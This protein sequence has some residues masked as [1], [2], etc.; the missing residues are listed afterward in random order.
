MV[1]IYS[2][3]EGLPYTVTGVDEDNITLDGIDSTAFTAYTTG[4]SLF[5]RQFY[6][7]KTWKRAYAGGIGFQHRIMFSASGAQD[8]YRIHALK[9]YFKARGKR[10]IN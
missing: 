6:R 9:P 3:E 8:P 4:G 2:G 5:F 10:L 7:T 1:E